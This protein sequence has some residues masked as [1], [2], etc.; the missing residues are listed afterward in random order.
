M[1]KQIEIFPEI[2]FWESLRESKKKHLMEKFGVK[3]PKKVFSNER[4]TIHIKTLMKIENQ[5]QS[6]GEQ[7]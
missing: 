7:K 3:D 5:N 2:K 6:K 4:L 1:T